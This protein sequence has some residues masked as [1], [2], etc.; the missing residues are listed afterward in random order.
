MLSKSLLIGAIA[1]VSTLAVG[2][3]IASAHDSK[4]AP[5]PT[6]TLA[7][8]LLSD[9]SGDDANGF[10]NRWW[11]YDIVTQAVLLFPDLVSAASD[12][13]AKLTAF[14]PNDRA[15]RILVKDLTGKWVKKESDVFDAVASLGTDTVKNVLLYHLIPA[16]I[17]YRDALASN[18]ASL[19]TLLAKSAITVE[20]RKS[21]N[22]H[23]KPRKFVRLVDLDPSDRDPIVVQPNIGGEALNGY[24]HGIDRVLRPLDL[25]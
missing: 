23:E 24:A 17:S 9:S 11:D 16:K 21:Q 10:D 18:G 25:P 22:K 5:A 7:Q 3:D 4:P 14:L 13:N 19:D 6:A 1:A 20:V 12:P 15:F 2:P 8:V